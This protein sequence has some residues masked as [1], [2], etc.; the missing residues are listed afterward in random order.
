MI[1]PSNLAIPKSTPPKT[2]I[3]DDQPSFTGHIAKTTQSCCLV[4]STS[5]R[6]DP[7]SLSMRHYSLLRPLWSQDCTATML[8]LLFVLQRQ[9]NHFSWFRMQQHSQS[10]KS[11][12]RHTLTPSYNQSR[13]LLSA[14]EQSL[15]C[16]LKRA[17]NHF[18]VQSPS[19]LLAGRIF[20]QNQSS[21]LHLSQHSK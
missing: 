10:S 7:I 20:F 5:G 1:S 4:Y 8:P 16:F 19:Q 18:P 13:T 9:P 17:V 15:K 11:P 6:L 14:N 21:W 12:N 3:F 2:V